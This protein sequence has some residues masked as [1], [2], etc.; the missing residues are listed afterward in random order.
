M[1]YLVKLDVLIGLLENVVIIH[2][3][4][5]WIHPAFVTILTIVTLGTVSLLIYGVIIYALARDEI[6]PFVAKYFHGNT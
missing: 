6:V 4:G 3:L 2:T 5:A 1:L